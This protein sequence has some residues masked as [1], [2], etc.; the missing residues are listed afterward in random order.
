LNSKKTQ[1]TSYKCHQLEVFKNELSDTYKLTIITLLLSTQK[2]A[3]N[4]II[5]HLIKNGCDF[6]SL[7]KLKKKR[8]QKYGSV[9]LM[10]IVVCV[11]VCETGTFWI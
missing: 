4:L 10:R 6:F 5:D 9:G 8:T 2:E 11:C 1:S 7:F 3:Q